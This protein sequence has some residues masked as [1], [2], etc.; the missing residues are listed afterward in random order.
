MKT[1][2]LS[3]LICALFLIAVPSLAS[4]HAT[5]IAHDRSIPA[6]EARPVHSCD[7][8]G[9][10]DYVEAVPEFTLKD[11]NGTA[12]DSTS[13]YKE[14]GMLLMITVPNLT[15][16]ERQKRWEKLIK[17]QGW[18]EN[19]APR[20]VVLEDLSQ[21]ESYK[22]KARRLMQDKSHEDNRE[23][24]L[25]DEDGNVRRQFG[26][27]QNETVILL[28]DN[29]GNVV[30]HEVDDVDTEIEA[31]RRVARLVRQ[32]ANALRSATVAAIQAPGES[33]K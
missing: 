2:A 32:L 8:N 18:P 28:I 27:Q 24:F 22:E 29:S 16:Y 31:S 23:L 20:C 19:N 6:S 9:P 17:Q 15:Q 10:G 14:R 25:V 4:D 3:S 1:A 7:G 11:C 5:N 33:G 12:H 30:H 21:Q 13:L 26:V